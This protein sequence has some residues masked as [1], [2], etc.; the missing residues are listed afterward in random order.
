MFA[1]RFYCK[2]INHGA[3]DGVWLMLGIVPFLIAVCTGGGIGT[4]PR[5]DYEESPSMA[6]GANGANGTYVTTSYGTIDVLE[7]GVAPIPPEMIGNKFPFSFA[8]SLGVG[9]APLAP[10][11]NFQGGGGGG[12]GSY[13]SIIVKNDSTTNA[14][15]LRLYSGAGGINDNERGGY[16][17]PGRLEYAIA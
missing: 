16:A 11:N 10:F 7:A 13:A 14:I 5:S 17:N 4:A 8:G 6:G 12:N 15:T 2:Y 9:T 3:I 1:R